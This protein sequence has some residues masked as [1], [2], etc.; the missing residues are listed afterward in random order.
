MRHLGYFSA[1]PC[2][3]GDGITGAEPGAKRRWDR[4][5]CMARNPCLGGGPGWKSGPLGTCAKIQMFLS[6]AFGFH[7]RVL[8]DV[9]DG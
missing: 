3:G 8:L 5:V 6:A 9:E 7:L 1:E 2:L 4:S